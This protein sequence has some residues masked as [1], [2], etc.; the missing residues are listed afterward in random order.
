MYM[1]KLKYNVFPGG[2]NYCLTMSYDDGRTFDI[3]LA[4]IFRENGIKGTFHLNSNHFEGNSSSY[5]QPSQFAEVYAGHEI[6]CHMYTHPFPTDIPDIAVLDEIIEDRKALEKGCG[7]VV[8]GMSYPYGNYDPR[9][10]NLCRA[11][12]MEYS[13]TTR[14][15][16]DFK[17]PDDFLVWH[18][19]C[20]HKHNIME[21]MEAFYAPSKYQRLKLFYV[22]GHSYEFNN[23]NNWELIEE[24]SK[25]I[26]G[27]EDTWYATNIEIVDYVNAIRA[28]RVS[29]DRTM[30]Y[31]PTATEVWF[32]IN[33]D[34]V[35]VKPGETF[36]L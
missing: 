29:A 3:R 18:P 25:R 6:S 11:A 7:Y 33:N 24:F 27:R 16:N 15:T 21:K 10:I 32:T 35:S 30:V 26:G 8:R 9:V 22:W 14:A 19:T 4:Q 36:K 20:H 28:L 31:N 1:N 23:D 12:G 5:V 13:R 34:I 2:K 17:L